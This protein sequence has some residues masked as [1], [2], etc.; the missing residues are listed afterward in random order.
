LRTRNYCNWNSCIFI[1]RRI[2]RKT[3]ILKCNV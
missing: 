1:K 3:Q 2:I